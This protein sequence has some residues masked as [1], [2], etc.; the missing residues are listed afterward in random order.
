MSG[1]KP[2]KGVM[3]GGEII[4]REDYPALFAALDEM[5]SHDDQEEPFTLPDLR[6]KHS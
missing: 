3:Y 5:L 6:E 4:T 1:E 2:E